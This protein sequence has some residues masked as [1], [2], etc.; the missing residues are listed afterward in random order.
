MLEELFTQGSEVEDLFC[1]VS[2]ISEPSLLFSRCHFGL[3]FKSVQDDFQHDF[4]AV[5]DKADGS[6]VLA[7]L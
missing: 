1:G 2:S 6:I 4:A 5:C 7:E 3:G